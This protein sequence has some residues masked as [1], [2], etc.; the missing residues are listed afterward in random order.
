MAFWRDLAMEYGHDG[1]NSMHSTRVTR[2]RA[3]VS[4]PAGSTVRQRSAHASDASARTCC[5]SQS[6]RSKP[7]TGGVSGLKASAGG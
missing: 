4:V 5:A 2:V 1:G 6:N 7:V 3:R